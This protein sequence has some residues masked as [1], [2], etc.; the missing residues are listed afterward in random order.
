[1]NTAP[2][3]CKILAHMFR[4]IIRNLDQIQHA[5]TSRWGFCP[6]HSLMT[7]ECALAASVVVLIGVRCH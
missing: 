3:R 4:R 2:H 6:L 7:I 5:P 1:M